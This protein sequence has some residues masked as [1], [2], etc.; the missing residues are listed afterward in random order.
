[1][2]MLAPLLYIGISQA[3]FA[4]FLVMTKKPRLLSD[5]FLGFW[6]L[7][8]F[9]ETAMTLYLETVKFSTPT[10]NFSIVLQVVYMPLMYL[11]VSMVIAEKP[12]LTVRFVKHLAP[13]L[14][15]LTLIYIYR[16]E[17]IFWDDKGDAAPFVFALR[18]IFGGYFLFSIILYTRLILK[19]LRKHQVVIQDQFSYTSERL[20]L[21]WLKF[22]LG[23]FV[24]AFFGQI[25]IGAMADRIHYPFDPR[26]FVRV[27]LTIFA[28][29]VSYFGVKQPTLYKQVRRVENEQKQDD[30]KTKY[31]RSGLTEENAREHKI[32][33]QNYMAAEKPFLD[34]ELTIKDIADYLEIPRH[35]IT[36]VINEK[37]NVNFFTW[38]NEYRIEEVKSRLLDARYS[39]L[40]IVAIAY[41]CGFNSKSA[42][43]SIFKK[44]TGQTPSGFRR[45]QS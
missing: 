7:M 8:I 29:G 10:L 21:N 38:I 41:D 32:K 18:F 23:L 22:V 4:A 25:L 26:L 30:Q 6:L 34:P 13:F 17:P 35:H 5:L 14:F 24:A 33:L 2:P 31:E 36:Q 9:V 43:N 19:T 15:F 37:L 27:A 39:H 45:L 44:A 11:Y 28:F 20:T 40:T 42:F 16:Q 1:M 3:F 12:Q